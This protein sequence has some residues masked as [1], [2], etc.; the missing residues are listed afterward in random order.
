MG[1]EGG[2]II[3]GCDGFTSNSPQRQGLFWGAD[4]QLGHNYVFTI[5]C[6]DNVRMT[7]CD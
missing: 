1:Q 3:T 4:A 2:G 5:P 7:C 6:G